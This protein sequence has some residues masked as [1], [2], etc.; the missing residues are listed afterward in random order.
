[1]KKELLMTDYG[2][3][4]NFGYF[5]TPEAADY[6]QL[7]ATARLVDE[8]GLD[9]IGIQDHPYQS[10]F[11]DTWTL[12]TAIATQTTRVR[13][14]PDVA[15]LPLRPPAVLAKAA[16][17]LDLISGSRFELGLGAGAFW[18]AIAAMGG[19]RREPGE[20]IAA[21][22]EAITIIRLMWST[23]RA[24]RFDGRF[25][26]LKGAHPGPVPPHPIGIWIGGYGPKMLNLTG[27]LA[28]GWLPSSAYA[29]P[30][31]LPEMNQR[32]DEGATSAGRDP[33]AIQRLYN[34]GGRIT[35]GPTA[36][37]LDGPVTQWV[38]E[39]TELTVEGGMDSY[40]FWPTAAPEEQLRRFALEVVP[41]VRENV[42]RSRRSPQKM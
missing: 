18:D 16:A 31:Q 32:I 13:V 15:N 24:V 38:D 25:Y 1:L 39:L 40:I 22:E 4:L 3:P 34:I 20:A 37:F 6:P 36:G 26:T 21:L 29:P 7:V 30:A 17:S 8:L 23:Q 35:T 42:E 2:R 27:R 5:L 11:L 9:L 41:Q 12:L 28:D 33:T 14:F 19:P 10:R